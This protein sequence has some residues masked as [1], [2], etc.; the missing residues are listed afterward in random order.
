MNELT[1]ERTKV[2]LYLHSYYSSFACKTD[3]QPKNFSINFRAMVVTV[4]SV[5]KSRVPSTAFQNLW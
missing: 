2:F 3:V 5:K 1:N 4:C